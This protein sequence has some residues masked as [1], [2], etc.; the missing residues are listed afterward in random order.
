MM[1][2]S[3]PEGQIFLSAPNSHDRFFF[4]HTF[5]SPAFDFNI[6]V[7]IN[8]SCSYT[9]TFTILKVDVT[10]TS[11]PSVL[12]TELCDL[13]YMY[14]QCIDNMCC[15]SF[16]IYPTGWIRVCKIRFVSTGENSGKPCLVCKN[17][18]SNIYIC[19]IKISKDLV[20]IVFVHYMLSATRLYDK[21]FT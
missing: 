2:N 17:R 18:S 3:D 19:S 10:M 12:T 5:L 11:T 7:A 9:L 8:E 6:G 15:Y 16:F 13:L 1:P 4:L 20:L 14:N 21:V